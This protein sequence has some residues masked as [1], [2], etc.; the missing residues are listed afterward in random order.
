MSAQARAKIAAAQRARWARAK[1]KSSSAGKSMAAS[2]PAAKAGKRRG[3]ITPEGRAK[4]AAAVKARWAERK[5]GGS[6]PNVKS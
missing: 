4:L 5:K 1:G 6:A 3:G 2:K